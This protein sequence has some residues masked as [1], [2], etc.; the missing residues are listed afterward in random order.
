[1]QFSSWKCMNISHIYT[2]F[3]KICR[4][5]AEFIHVFFITHCAE[6]L[7]MVADWLPLFFLCNFNRLVIDMSLTFLFSSTFIFCLHNLEYFS[8]LLPAQ[9]SSNV[10]IN[11]GDN[12][13]LITMSIFPENPQTFCSCSSL[14]TRRSQ[15]SILSLQV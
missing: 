7:V 13:F 6:E 4:T 3:T 9:I 15:F 2:Q 11:F 14:L 1:M 12:I 5:R 8:F 10:F